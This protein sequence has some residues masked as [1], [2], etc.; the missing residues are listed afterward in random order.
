MKCKMLDKR[1]GSVIF[2][3]VRQPINKYILNKPDKFDRESHE[4]Y[5][6]NDDDAWLSFSSLG[7]FI[8]T[9]SCNYHHSQSSFS[10]QK[11][12]QT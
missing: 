6:G 12:V 9:H 3:L 4:K 1:N 8:S 7:Y 11:L 5:D 2:H 10:H